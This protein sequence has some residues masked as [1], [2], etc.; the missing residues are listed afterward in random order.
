MIRRVFQSAFVAFSL[1]AAGAANAQSPRIWD[2]APQ[3][4]DSNPGTERAPFLTIQRAADVVSPGDTVIV[5]DGVYTGVGTGTSCGSSSRPVVCLSRGGTA[6]AWVTI[7]ARHAGGAKLD[8]RSNT[9]THGFYF[10]GA[11][12]VTISGFEIFGMGSSS[13]AAHGVMIDL[14]HDVVLSQLHLHDIGRFLPGENGCT[15]NTAAHFDHA[16]YVSG[17]YYS[18]TTPGASDM[19]ITNNIFYR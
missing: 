1:A 12:Y 7:Q 14:G 8:G 11:S 6:D 17:E 10:K 15:A 19:L 4:N 5:E 13:G 3:G 9:S 16:I 2:V 18:S